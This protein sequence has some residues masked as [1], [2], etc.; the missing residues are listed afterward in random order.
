[1][2]NPKKIIFPQKHENFQTDTK[3]QAQR[4]NRITNTKY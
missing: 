1:M 4:V 2:G 3:L